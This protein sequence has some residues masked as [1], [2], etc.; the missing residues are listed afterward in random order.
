MF[1]LDVNPQIRLKL[2][3]TRD[4]GDLFNLIDSQRPYLGAWLPW[5]KH[6]QAVEDSETF[7]KK[8][9]RAWKAGTALHLG[10]IYCHHL[11]GMIGY[12]ELDDANRSASIGYWLSDDHQGNGIMLRSCAALIEYGFTR[13]HLH[14][15]EIRC[16]GGN[17]ASRAIPE[18]LGFLQEGVHRDAELLDAGFVDHVCY[19]LLAPDWTGIP[20]LLS[21]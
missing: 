12:H 4:S 18:R 17:Q 20:A 15:I 19:G 21:E 2:L 10:V 6:V 13:S 9:A 8:S 14:R 5:V 1:A 11:S 3:D 16:A 7:I